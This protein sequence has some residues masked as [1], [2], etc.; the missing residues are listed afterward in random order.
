MHQKRPW[1]VGNRWREP[2]FGNTGFELC[3]HRGASKITF[4]ILKISPLMWIKL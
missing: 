4:L 2:V 3:L 1:K